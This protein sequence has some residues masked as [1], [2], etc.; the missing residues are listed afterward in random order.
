MRHSGICSLKTNFD[1]A[2]D[3]MMIGET[4]IRRV[5]QLVPVEDLAEL[6]PHLQKILN[7]NPDAVVAITSQGKPVMA[8][9][10]WESWED[11]EDM[12]TTWET[13]E[14]TADPD[15]M[16]ALRQSRSEGADALIPGDAAV[17]QL[18]V[19]GLIGAEDL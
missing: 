17:Q 15:A 14:V 18:I 2:K 19:E 5:A 9:L 11:T 4:D 12:A 6:L 8:L 13:L 16:A 3:L 7:A 1:C 10:P